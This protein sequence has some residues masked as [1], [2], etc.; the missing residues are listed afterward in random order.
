[1]IELEYALL[2]DGAA[3]RADGKL[4]VF[5]AGVDMI[6]AADVPTRHPSIS[7]VA[8][9]FAD[10]K[11]LKETHALEIVFSQPDGE[12]IARAEQ[13][14]S[15][16]A[17]EAITRHDGKHGIGI[18]LQFAGMVFPEYGPYEIELLMDGKALRGPLHLSVL[19][20]TE[21]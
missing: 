4:D 16:V 3:P 11:D 12:E 15:P 13:E 5:G 17:D 9:L 10:A 6:Y 8:R 19:E 14:I 18:V 21:T 7:L 20:P 2:A 1:M